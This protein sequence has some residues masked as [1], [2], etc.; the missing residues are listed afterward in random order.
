MLFH[1]FKRRRKPLFR[2]VTSNEIQ[3]LLLA[4]SDFLRGNLLLIIIGIVLFLFLFFRFIWALVTF[5]II[6]NGVR[7]ALLFSVAVAASAGYVIG[8]IINYIKNKFNINIY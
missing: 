2:F 8:N 6:L 7:F 1:F 3:H 5:Y 4:F